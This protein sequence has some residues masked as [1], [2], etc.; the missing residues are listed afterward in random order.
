MYLFVHSQGWEVGGMGMM[1]GWWGIK[2]AV[3]CECED[4]VGVGMRVVGGGI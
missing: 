2:G 1:R 4:M 3:V